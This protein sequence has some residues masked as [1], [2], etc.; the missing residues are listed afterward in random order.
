MTQSEL[1]V[2]PKVS[3]FHR[4]NLRR[5]AFAAFWVMLGSLAILWLWPGMERVFRVG[6]TLL[7]GGLACLLAAAWFL[8]LESCSR[9]FKL[10]VGFALLCAGIAAG[11]T[12]RVKEFSGDL[13]PILTW[14]WAPVQDRTL[15]SLDADQVAPQAL[16]F[17]K[18]AKP[19][20][21]PRFL[22]QD[23][24]G[25]V[26]GLR[27]E[28]DWTSHPPRKIWQKTVGAGWS[29]FAVVGD[30]G[31]TQEQRGDHECVT[32]YDLKNGEI[33]WSHQ[34]AVR[35]SEVMGGDGPRATPTIVDGRIYTLGATGILN[36][37]EGESGRVIWSR[38]TLTDLNQLNLEWGKS[39]S[40]LVV[41]N[42]VVVS[43]G[44]PAPEVSRVLPSLADGL[45]AF[46]RN[47]GR[48]M[49]KAG[50]DSAAYS[51]PVVATLGGTSQILSL[52]AHS[53]S[54]HDPKTGWILWSRPWP[55]SHPKCSNPFVMNG[56][57]VLLSAGYGLGGVL[58]KVSPAKAGS[59]WVVEEV[60]K[61][62]Q[63]KTRFTNVVQ[64]G[65]SLYG[66]DDG[67]LCCVD[68]D[69]GKTRWRKGRYSH[70]QILL[71][72]DVLLIQAENGDLALVKADPQSYQELAHV[73]ALQ[74]KTWNTPTLAG[75]RLLVR[76]AEEAI[77][78]E[79]ALRGEKN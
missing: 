65:D 78:Y 57:R 35:F 58:L 26:K 50:E 69:S 31:I 70:G 55:G 5:F 71:V 73:P 12:F 23:G 42:I 67:I 64:K 25:E 59:Q 38:K 1:P 51:S 22:G 66:L 45:A 16:S 17:P 24:R 49:W 30:Y 21:S 29:A 54:A 53:L 46:D 18:T 37:L 3:R 28:T 8:L 75:N 68:A 36:C 14:R 9:R 39:A 6:G 63:L 33:L 47:S 2:P 27:L 41:G 4:R 20:D 61:S 7:L 52:N 72:G 56:D 19:S 10:G 79:L 15:Q 48:L 34:D 77:C 62:R 60:W 44:R 11:L 13:I 76:N 40:P 32:C 43:L 74:G